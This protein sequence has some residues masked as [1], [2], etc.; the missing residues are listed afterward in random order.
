MVAAIESAISFSDPETWG[1]QESC[2]NTVFSDSCFCSEISTSFLGT[3]EI[4]EPQP[5]PNLDPIE[6]TVLQTPA[7]YEIAFFGD[8]S[9]AKEPRQFDVSKE[10][11]LINVSGT[12]STECTEACDG[13]DT[14]VGFN[15]RTFNGR[16]LCELV[17][18]E[19][20]QTATAASVSYRKRAANTLTG[21]ISGLYVN[22]NVLHLDVCL[23]SIV[24]MS[25]FS[26]SV[27]VDSRNENPDSTMT[28]LRA[29][30]SSAAAVFQGARVALSSFASLS[31][32]IAA[33]EVIVH[34][35][36][37][38]QQGIFVPACQCE[39]GTVFGLTLPSA[40]CGTSLSIGCPNS[41]EGTARVSCTQ[42]LLDDTHPF[43]SSLILL[44]E[45]ISVSRLLRMCKSCVEATCS[46]DTCSYDL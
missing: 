32:I 25:N 41:G 40:A 14:C 22:V 35:L 46:G 10:I 36:A 43:L 18:E 24:F 33:Q 11:Q 39:G 34:S 20:A 38:T 4:Q 29:A 16:T 42:V 9:F 12:D 5:L 19:V 13:K 23:G 8:F 2:Q 27:F 7:G 30:F 44:S 15:F 1:F 37:I 17:S 26:V 6:N 45:R 3:S 28:S 21:S 31:D